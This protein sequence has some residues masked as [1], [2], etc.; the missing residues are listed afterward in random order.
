M[1]NNF[2]LLCF[3]KKC[4]AISAFVSRLKKKIYGV[5][6]RKDIFSIYCMNTK[7]NKIAGWIVF[8]VA[9]IVYFLTAERVGSLWD[10]GEFITGSYKLEVV[11][12]PGA[13]LF[14][15]IGRMFTLPADWFSSDP[16]MISFS[17]NL[18]S[19]VCSAFAAAF[20]C[21]T[22]GI[23]GRLALVGR[24][25]MVS[26]NEEWALGG[27]GLAAGL[28]TAFC[29]SIWFS[30]VEG[31]VYA[32]STFFTALVVWSAA[33]WY[34]LPD[35]AKT[36][37]WFIFCVYAAGLSIGVHLLSLLAFPAIG[38]LYYI[39]KYREH[40]FWG[41]VAAALIG[42]LFF[43]VVVQKFIVVGIPTLWE[44]TELMMVN[45]FGLPF[46]SGIFPTVLIIGGLIYAGFHYAH[47]RNSKV[48]Q[49]ITAS[50]LMLVLGYSTVGVVVIRANANTPINMNAPSDPIR[51]I[52]YI[53]R[54]QYGERELLR[55]PWY[56]AGPIDTET[57][58][59]YGQVGDRYEIVDY[60]VSYKWNPRDMS[61]FPRMQDNQGSRAPIYEMWR[62]G[63]KGKP[64][65]GE[66]IGFTLR[67]QIGW[68]YWRYF[69]W[70]FI[71]RQNAEQG[72]YSWDVKDGN[73]FSGIK[74]LDEARLY[75]QDELPQTILNDK[76][77]NK[78][79]ALP[80]I[81]GLLGLFFHFKNRPNE[82]LSLMA[83]FIITGIGIILYSNQPPNE[84]RERD[85]VLVGS[86]MTYCIWLGMG[87][88]AIYELMRNSLKT[89]G[90]VSAIAASAIV[91]V[92]PILM[93]TQNFDD[94]DR[95]G[96]VASRDYAANFL[97]TVEK[98]QGSII[99]TYGDNDT[100]PLWYAQET[101][102]IRTD[103]RV[104]NLSL[105]AVDWYIEQLR[106]KT[107]ESPAVN[108]TIPTAAYRGNNR[109]TVPI[110]DQ[111][112]VK[113][114]SL[115]Q[116]L[117][118]MAKDL[119]NSGNDPRSPKTYLP[120]RRLYIDVDKAKVLA[121]GTVAPE[122]ADKIV[123]RVYINIPKNKTYLIKDEL[124][125]LDVIGSNLWERPVYF[126]V[127]CRPEKMF[128]LQDYMQLEGL[129][130]RIVPIKTE[131]SP[132]RRQYGQVYGAGRVATDK[133]YKHFTEDYAYGNFDKEDLF[134]DHSY[135]PS[136]QS[137]RVALL[138]T[139]RQML[140]E[141]D[142]TRAVALTDK[143]FEG[144]PHMNFPYDYNTMYLINVYMAAGAFDKAQPHLEIMAEEA[145]DWL[146]F[147]SSLSPELTDPEN[148]FG[149]Y[150]DFTLMMRT[151]Q[152]VVRAAA[153]IEDQAFRDK[154][155]GLLESFM[156]VPTEGRRPGG[157]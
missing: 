10:C 3:L 144:F 74:P 152:D 79:F 118:F 43:A 75:N 64:G 6:F 140:T 110:S 55:G 151:A 119:P 30:A 100:Y 122:D 2:L 82:A 8:A 28:A 78:Y 87:V 18:L 81:F 83:L 93:G 107:N 142:S 92:A 40:K 155:Q 88:L 95:S 154:I 139:V 27:A 123:D 17:V 50:V 12:P 59:R 98:D 102:E 103:V 97:N 85:Y 104:A 4:V 21:W 145:A 113:E 58:P 51:L 24:E 141:G 52:P 35:S 33:K 76:A 127:T 45:G 86:F 71:G 57:T 149:F 68:M 106:R 136:V 25:G 84:P 131:L 69:F 38:M 91:L 67:Y 156:Q 72:Y 116:A 36:D 90:K 54:E 108:L 15:L 44:K 89:S 49:M 121:N 66:N 5:L 63:E 105:I 39:K 62:G 9:F 157:R 115:K 126:A 112:N 53:N 23:F 73:W 61:L 48:L 94:H 147:Y 60:K 150:E 125:I 26:E 138:R 132:E 11:H 101:E 37:R 133:V 117:A 14:L 47:K 135:G 42:V 114:M 80:F 34:A 129:G 130:L 124:A 56:G 19:G 96:I 46:H 143:Y 148:D 65:L 77:R 1:F 22:T 7:A 153:E 99:F 134:V 20:I 128:G 137:H 16:A 120:T 13:P 31:E 41:M 32:M 70:N 29:S 146:N 109:N 111:G